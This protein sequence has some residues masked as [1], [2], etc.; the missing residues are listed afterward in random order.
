METVDLLLKE[1]GSNVVSTG[2]GTSVLEVARLMNEKRI[3]AV[4]VVENDAV[5]GILTERD[6]LTKVVANG[7][8]P[9]E[10]QVREIMSKDVV[11]VEPGTPI[12]EAMA[13]MT[14]LRH[15]HLPVVCPKRGICGMISI[16]D[17]NRWHSK[18][19]EY[20]LLHLTDYIQGKYR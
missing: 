19:Q 3:G 4:L 7:A 10:I 2:P 5:A 12:K 14:E 13:I 20:T 8:N 16:G 11:F 6:L 15:R 1:K 17:C 9:A 18:N